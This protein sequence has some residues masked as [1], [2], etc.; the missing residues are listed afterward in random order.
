MIPPSLVLLGLACDLVELNLLGYDKLGIWMSAEFFFILRLR[1]PLLGL[2]I[3]IS[4]LGFLID[5][6]GRRYHCTGSRQGHSKQ[7]PI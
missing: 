3:V 2:R 5:A 6:F 1:L 7:D 4:I